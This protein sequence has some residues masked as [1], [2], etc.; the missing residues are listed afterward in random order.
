MVNL[1]MSKFNN[2]HSRLKIKAL[3]TDELFG[4]ELHVQI[5]GELLG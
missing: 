4:L 5:K 2:E 3:V 1:K